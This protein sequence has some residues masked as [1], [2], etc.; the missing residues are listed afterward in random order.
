MAL[1]APLRWGNGKGGGLFSIKLMEKN[2]GEILHL[3]STVLQ[4][5]LPLKPYSQAMKM[6]M[7]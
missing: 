5:G 7:F 1:V 2:K 4:P 3:E 6:V